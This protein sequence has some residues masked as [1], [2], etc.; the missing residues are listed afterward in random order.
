MAFPLCK[1]KFGKRLRHGNFLHDF[2]K[3]INILLAL[4]LKISKHNQNTMSI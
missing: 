1:Q 3:L 4:L 2:D